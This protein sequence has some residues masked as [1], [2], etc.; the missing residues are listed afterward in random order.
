[1]KTTLFLALL[2]LSLGSGGCASYKAKGP[3]YSPSASTPPG[4]A[5]IYIY[6][7]PHETFG[8]QR[9]YFVYANGSRLRDLKF[10]GYYPYETPPGDIQLSSVTKLA[11]GHVVDIAIER[12]AVGAAKLEFKAQAGQ[13]YYVKMH[14]ES[15]FT[16]I[17]PKLFLM[18][19]SDAQGEIKEC[20]LL[21]R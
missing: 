10:G 14:P 16:Y 12:S 2:I 3:L 19:N 5:V 21:A 7:P 15:H 4:Q 1:M 9:V 11:F 13:A 17:Q 20:K 8:W 18:T 6:R